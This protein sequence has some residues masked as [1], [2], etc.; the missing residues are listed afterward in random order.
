MVYIF[1]VAFRNLELGYGAA[2]SI[3]NLVV[4]VTLVLIFFAFARRWVHYERV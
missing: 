4:L 3:V 1:R 2:I